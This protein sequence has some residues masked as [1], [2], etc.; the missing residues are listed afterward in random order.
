MRR[1]VIAAAAGLALLAV[2]PVA[3]ADGPDVYTA[4]LT[5]LNDS[6]VVGQAVLTMGGGGLEVNLTVAGTERE[7][8]H[9]QHIHGLAEAQAECPTIARDVNRDG[10]VDVG[11]GLPDYGPVLLSLRPFPTAN[12]G[13]VVKTRETYTTVDSGAPVSSLMPL[14]SRVVV[15]HGLD[16]NGNGRYDGGFETAM[17]VACGHIVPRG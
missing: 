7:L 11:E 15:I 3:S 12:P 14:E 17:P 16:V 9:V 1:I 13:G 5:E 2:V 8:L 10:F 4:H 6:G